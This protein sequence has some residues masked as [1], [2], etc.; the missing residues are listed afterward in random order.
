M[1]CR[2][3]RYTSP[4][5]ISSA[6]WPLITVKYNIVSP[7]YWLGV[8]PEPLVLSNS[9]LIHLSTQPMGP[10]LNIAKGPQVPK[11]CCEDFSIKKTEKKNRTLYYSTSYPLPATHAM[12][13]HIVNNYTLILYLSRQVELI[14]QVGFMVIFFLIFF[15]LKRLI[16]ME[17]ESHKLHT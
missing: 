6:A 11:S 4:S 2:P 17:K 15:K 10:V 1:E 9:C 16:D 5:L 13:Q 3:S 8:P 7:K 12:F 14:F